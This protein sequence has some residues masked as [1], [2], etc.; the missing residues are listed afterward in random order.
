LY[1][2]VSQ[3]EDIIFGFQFGMQKFSCFGVTY[4]W[5]NHN[6]FLKL[7]YWTTNFIHHDLNVMHIEKNVFEIFLTQSWMSKEKKTTI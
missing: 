7:T 6:I 4:N 3:F 5:V 2:V 1:D